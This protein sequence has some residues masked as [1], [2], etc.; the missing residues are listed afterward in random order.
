MISRL[1][2]ACSRCCRDRSTISPASPATPIRR[3]R[4]K[5]SIRPSA[6]PDYAR[7]FPPC[8]RKPGLPFA[9]Q[10]SWAI[11]VIEFVKSG[12]AQVSS[13][14]F[15]I[16][17]DAVAPVIPAFLIQPAWV[18]AE[19]NAARLERRSQFQEHAGQFTS[20]YVKQRGVGEN[21]VKTVVRQIEREKILLPYVKAFCARHRNK[22]RTAFQTH[23]C[24]TELG[25]CLE[26]A[27]RPAT[28]IEHGR[29]RCL[30]DMLQQRRDVLAD[31]VILCT[32]AEFLGMVIVMF[33]RAGGDMVQRMRIGFHGG[34]V[35]ARDVNRL[36]LYSTVTTIRHAA[37]S[38]P[39]RCQVAPYTTEGLQ[40]ENSGHQGIAP[41]VRTTAQRLSATV[42]AIVLRTIA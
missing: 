24:M 42:K 29:R 22:P 32:V 21:A 8:G 19:E 34:H 12:V 26:I 17:I 30:L 37:V 33:Q 23:R 40:G 16:V 14:A 31:V 25:K 28:E 39:T 18:G 36:L 13:P 11:V 5:W 1:S 20:R 2:T 9:R 10:T 15:E 6:E 38:A 27:P 41:A 4:T 35:T 7:L 3:G